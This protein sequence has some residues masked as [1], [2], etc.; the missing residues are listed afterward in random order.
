MKRVQFTRPRKSAVRAN[1]HANVHSGRHDCDSNVACLNSQTGC[2]RA[3]LINTRLHVRHISV[4]DFPPTGFYF[5]YLVLNNSNEN[6]VDTPDSNDDNYN[7]NHNHHHHNL[8]I[9][10][11][12]VQMNSN[13]NM[14]IGTDLHIYRSR[15]PAVKD[16]W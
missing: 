9:K 14:Q 15:R 11:N 1:A 5:A 16:S 8:Y 2:T 6:N 10:C 13:R 4:L 12:E 3:S 7:N